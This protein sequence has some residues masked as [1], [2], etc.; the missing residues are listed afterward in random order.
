MSKHLINPDD[1]NDGNESYIFEISKNLYDF[2]VNNINN[3]GIINKKCSE[4]G[5]Y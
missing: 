4:L 2:I 1:S 3:G 5:L